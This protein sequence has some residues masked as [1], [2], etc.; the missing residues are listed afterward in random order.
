MAGVEGEQPRGYSYITT[1]PND[2]A[3]PLQYSITCKIIVKIEIIAVI[4][5]GLQSMRGR[6]NLLHWIAIIS[7][8]VISA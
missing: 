3:I 1:D 7:V 6:Y 5:I 2:T 4:A 8:I